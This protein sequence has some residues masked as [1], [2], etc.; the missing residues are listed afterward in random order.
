MAALSMAITASCE[1][2]LL[3]PHIKLQTPE[4]LIMKVVAE[5]KIP[6]IGPLGLKV[7]K[8]QRTHPNEPF[9]RKFQK[10]RGW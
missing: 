2:V 4:E 1:V 3:P 5:I 6:P 10:R 9:Y 7:P 8:R